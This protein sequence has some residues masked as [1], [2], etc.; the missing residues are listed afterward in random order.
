M[1]HVS[2]AYRVRVKD[3]AGET[4]AGK[5]D[6]SKQE[7]QWVFVPA[8]PWKRDSYRLVVDPV[9]E[10]VAGNRMTGLFD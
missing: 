8:Q 4:V 6:L 7:Q 10:D 3:K 2:L 5:I 1:D 9:L